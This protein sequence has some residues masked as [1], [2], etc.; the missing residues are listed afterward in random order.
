MKIDQVVLTDNEEKNGQN[1]VNVYVRTARFCTE[2]DLAIPVKS[3]FNF[4]LIRDRDLGVQNLKL[5]KSKL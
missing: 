3:D 2:I 5:A 1:L 4:D